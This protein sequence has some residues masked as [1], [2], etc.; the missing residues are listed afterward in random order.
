M[1]FP[2]RGR[3]TASSHD[4]MECRGPRTTVCMCAKDVSRGIKTL[5][6]RESVGADLLGLEEILCVSYEHLLYA[7][8]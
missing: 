2:S 6:R 5:K 3:H 4:G 1:T 7:R 8:I